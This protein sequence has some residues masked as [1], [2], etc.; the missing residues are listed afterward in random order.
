MGGWKTISEVL[1]ATKADEFADQSVLYIDGPNKDLTVAADEVSISPLEKNS[2]QLIVNGDA[3]SGET[4]QF[5][6][7]MSRSIA[8]NLEVDVNKSGN[9]LFRVT[10]HTTS[11]DGIVQRID[12]HCRVDS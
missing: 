10:D 1:T 2:E 11:S 12:G 3:E 9:R 5:C 4:A 6:R 8:T 7:L